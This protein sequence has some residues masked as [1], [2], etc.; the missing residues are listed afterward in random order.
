MPNYNCPRCGFMTHIKTH[1]GAHLDRKHLCSPI[2]SDIKLDEY[3][4]D[5]LN[6]R[7]IVLDDD[8]SQ[9]HPISSQTHSE[10]ISKPITK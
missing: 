9:N 7:D 6:N 5:I 4:D 1:M 10:I 2:L 3:R 8:I